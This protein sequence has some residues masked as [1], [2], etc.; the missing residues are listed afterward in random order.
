MSQT[1]LEPEIPELD[2]RDAG[3]RD[4][5]PYDVGR[6]PPIYAPAS[7]PFPWGCLIGG[8]LMTMLLM[9][10][11]MAVVGFGAYRYFSQQIVQNTSTEP[12]NL[13]VV[14]LS[15]DEMKEIETRI[16]TF[17]KK[18]DQG[19]APDTL[20][21]TAD[22]L[23][24]LIGQQEKLRERVFVKIEDGLIQADISFPTDGFPGGKGRYF[25]GSARVDASLENGKL[26]V[27]LYS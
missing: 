1:P 13:P 19:Q 18:V 21:L 16:D 5:S 9:V 15:P 26:V 4:P 7:K 24:A 25:N 17:Q 8:C 20:V 11:G 2:V 3:S 12:R 10:G 27:T 6:E 23:N 22:E 14:E